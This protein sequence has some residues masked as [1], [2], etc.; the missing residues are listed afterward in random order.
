M[1]RFEVVGSG[2]NS[3]ERILETPLCRKVV[4][5]KHADRTRGQIELPGV[6]TAD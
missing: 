2:A 6:V 4:L 3:Q 5:L 1:M